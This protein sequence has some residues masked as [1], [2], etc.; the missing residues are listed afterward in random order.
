MGKAVEVTRD[1]LTAAE[2]RAAAAKCTDGAQVRRILALAM[3]LEG[4]PP[5][6][7]LYSSVLGNGHS[8]AVG[9]NVPAWLQYNVVENDGTTNLA[10]DQGTVTFW[11]APSSIGSPARS[12][13]WW[14]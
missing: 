5:V 12:L 4:R 13:T 2:L 9:T 1:D 11:F 3:V 8:L 10:V 6:T 14:P 7:N